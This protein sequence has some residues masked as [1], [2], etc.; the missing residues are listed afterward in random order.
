MLFNFFFQV[1]FRVART[2]AV[3]CFFFLLFVE[4]SEKGRGGVWAEQLSTHGAFMAGVDEGRKEGGSVSQQDSFDFEQDDLHAD[5]DSE[6][7]EDSDG[8]GS[9]FDGNDDFDEYEVQ[10]DTSG[11]MDSVD[12]MHKAFWEKLNVIDEAQAEC[13]S[14]GRCAYVRAC[15]R[16][17]LR[18]SVTAL[19]ALGEEKLQLQ[20]TLS[21]LSPLLSATPS[22]LAFFPSH[23]DSD[24]RFA[25]LGHARWRCSRH[26][27]GSRVQQHILCCQPQRQLICG[28]QP[29]TRARHTGHIALAAHLRAL[30]HQQYV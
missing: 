6:D 12:M 22:A 20:V 10:A 16:Q 7:S 3:L 5:Q 15:Q 24:A 21:V 29:R 17:N 30:F 23:K 8:W 9:E 2:G 18:P 1:F 28:C 4:S 27:G 13:D 14:T 19:L 25:V 11:R 26:R